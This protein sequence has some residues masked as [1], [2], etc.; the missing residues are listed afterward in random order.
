L[1]SFV[2]LI[3]LDGIGAETNVFSAWIKLTELQSCCIY[4]IP[5]L[6]VTFLVM[7]SHPYFVT[8]LKSIKALSPVTYSC[9]GSSL[10]FITFEVSQYL[11]TFY[12]DQNQLV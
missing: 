4:L 1:K 9:A 7:L 11:D 3:L 2:S 5:F 6:N 10:T 8:F 12:A